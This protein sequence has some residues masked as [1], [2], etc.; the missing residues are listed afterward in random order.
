MNATNA[1]AQIRESS[2]AQR[3]SS[4][5][6]ARVYP[7]EANGLLEA[8]AAEKKAERIVSCVATLRVVLPVALITMIF[9]S[10]QLAPKP[11]EVATLGANVQPI[12]QPATDYFPAGYV[13]QATVVEDHVQNF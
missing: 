4:I 5:S 10:G 11:A 6:T 3:T 8:A 12:A 1:N 7:L 2:A 9:A 13:N